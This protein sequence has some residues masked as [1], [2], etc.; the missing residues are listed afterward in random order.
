M[1][2][3]DPKLSEPGAG[4]G[5]LPVLSQPAAAAEPGEGP[6]HDP[7]SRQHFEALG[8]VGALDDLQGPVADRLEVL[9]Q[10]GAGVSAVGEGVAQPGKGLADRRED[11]RSAVV[12]PEIGGVN[13]EADQQTEGV[14]D[15]MTLASLAPPPRGRFFLPAS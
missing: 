5:L 7:S 13:G 8:G 9:V 15:D 1:P 14:G 6:L 12:V 11:K 4:D 3:F 2:E 10:F